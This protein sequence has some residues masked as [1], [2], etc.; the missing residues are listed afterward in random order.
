MPLRILFCFRTG[1]LDGRK[2]CFPI[3]PEVRTGVA[4]GTG[5][6]PPAIDLAA[7]AATDDFEE[8]DDAGDGFFHFPAVHIEDERE[9]DI[10]VLEVGDGCDTDS[11]VGS[12]VLRAR[13]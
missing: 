8:L 9:E 4:T 12:H 6:H 10:R 2:N 5:F 1:S 3:F 7:E 11:G 13:Q